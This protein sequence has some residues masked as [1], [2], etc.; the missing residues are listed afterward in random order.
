[1]RSFPAQITPYSMPRS[2]RTSFGCDM[3][4]RLEDRRTRMLTGAAGVPNLETVP[5]RTECLD[6]AQPSLLNIAGQPRETKCSEP[7]ELSK[8]GVGNGG[9]NW[10]GY[11]DLQQPSC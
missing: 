9:D 8:A 1:M 11:P 10:T 2:L 6:H 5:C 4:A 7:R 3:A